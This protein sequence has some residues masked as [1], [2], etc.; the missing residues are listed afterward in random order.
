MEYYT[1]ITYTNKDTPQQNYYDILVNNL[2]LN[3]TTQ[4][5]PN[6]KL[7]QLL[8]TCNDATNEIED[9]KDKLQ[10]VYK[11]K[12]KLR[13]E[14]LQYKS[15]IA[16]CEKDLQDTIMKDSSNVT[17]M[18]R[19][20]RRNHDGLKTDIMVCNTNINN[21]EK[22][23]E[24]VEKNIIDYS[25]NIGVKA[26]EHDTLKVDIDLK[27]IAYEMLLNG[28]LHNSLT[29][30][31][32]DAI[33]YLER[34]QNA[35]QQYIARLKSSKQLEVNKKLN[36][37]AR[38]DNIDKVLIQHKDKL[39]RTKL[40]IESKEKELADILIY[41]TQAKLR[42]DTTQAN[43]NT[44]VN[45][46]QKL[47]DKYKVCMSE[48]TKLYKDNDEAIVKY[49]DI[50][51]KNDIYSDDVVDL[52]YY[53]DLMKDT[54]SFVETTLKPYGFSSIVDK[55]RNMNYTNGVKFKDY[56][57]NT[58]VILSPKLFSHFDYMYS[59]KQ[60]YEEAMTILHQEET[61]HNPDIDTMVDAIIDA[62]YC[63]IDM[64][65]NRNRQ[66]SLS[67]IGLYSNNKDYN[68]NTLHSTN[69]L[70]TKIKDSIKKDSLL[71]VINIHGNNSAITNTYAEIT[72][73]L[74][75]TKNDKDY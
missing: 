72:N 53:W 35:C 75:V 29:S 10:I 64:I 5:I 42:I 21:I 25:I 51:A 33:N 28:N 59:I 58:K 62:S 39:N 46:S 26:K 6:S 2:I 11:D 70:I 52:D 49:L 65:G 3:N 14:L 66:Y 34:E 16:Q 24:D 54:F 45:E 20:L 1:D 67:S 31:L 69:Q 17:S 13:K 55:Y 23:I 4:G 48:L 74:K 71:R 12:N 41:N 38:K 37:L 47:A 50:Y 18:L 22:E 7:L 63:I 30:N 9:I 56:S 15:I 27:V 19:N 61:S 73:K 36:L 43:K 32:K 44:A 8:V 57:G 68:T 60:Y 40:M